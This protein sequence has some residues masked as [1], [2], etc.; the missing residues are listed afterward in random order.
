MLV[1]VVVEDVN[2][3]VLPSAR[4]TV[5]FHSVE[6]AP[7]LTQ[8]TAQPG[9]PVDLP[10]ALPQFQLD[11]VVQDFEAERILVARIGD[12]WQASNGATR[13]GTGPAQI[14][15]TV[16]VGTVRLAPTVAWPP[17]RLTN[18]NPHA[19]LVDDTG[20]P[21][22]I[23]RGAYH[24]IETIRR[25]D[26]PI[27][28]DLT[29]IEWDRFNNTQVKIDIARLGQLALL[30]YG[31]RVST[32][33]PRFLIGTWIPS[34]PVANPPEVVV[35]YPPPTFANRGFPPDRHPFLENYPYAVRP[36]DPK[37]TPI[38]Q[39]Y[40]DIVINYL[41]VGYKIIYQIL[42]AGRNPIIIMPSQPSANWGPLASQPGLGRLIKEILRFLYANRLVSGTTAAPAKLRITG[43]RSFLF[44]EYG[45]FRDESL[46]P[47]FA[48][49]VS[50]FSAG[51]N[52]VMDVCTVPTIDT[53]RYTPALFASPPAVLLDDWRELW[54]MDGV[55]HEGWAAMTKIMNAW[56]AQPARC[57]RAYHS[58]T[59]YREQS[60]G[61]VDPKYVE[62]RPKHP[63]GGV[64]AEE[65]HRPDHRVTW[66]HFSNPSLEGNIQ[67]PGHRKD[68]PEFGT[69][70]AHHMVPAIG[71][72]HAAQFKVPKK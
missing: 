40:V 9:T 30:E 26:E 32:R 58:Q 28:G 65:G 17:D 69:L 31:G 6:S 12:R 35:F 10:L 14:D 2:G 21:Q 63:I 20:G 16:T 66:A 60:N 68:I 48:A 54:D 44:P 23:Y 25:L 22:W 34:N 37:P 72:G 13:I 36:G 52:A 24:N 43:G 41:L 18:E 19:A 53:K 62:R 39:P 51:I 7:E 3:T 61:L 45:N 59:T 47:H 29:K 33:I 38:H 55:Y 27:W 49:T 5:T 71:F 4:I 56:V 50:G 15:V 8:I 46:P 64:Y 11:I 57:L 42:A 1:K 67:A 70:D